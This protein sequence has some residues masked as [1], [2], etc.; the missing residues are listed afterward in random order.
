M[1]THY[2]HFKFTILLITM[3]LLLFMRV[4]TVGVAGSQWAIDAVAAVVVIAAVLAACTRKRTR[5]AAILFS[6]PPL[7]LTVFAQIDPPQ[8][9]PTTYVLLKATSATFL[10]FMTLTIVGELLH[11][12][13]I[14]R[15]SLAGAFCGYLLIGFSWSD[16]FCWIDLVSPG[17][18]SHA[19]PVQV[20]GTVESR[21]RLMHYFSFVTLT[22]IGYGDIVPVSPVA[23]TL[24]C[25]EAICGQF[26]LAILVAGLVSVRISQLSNAGKSAD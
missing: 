25:L 21:S 5:V 10:G 1:I 23:R 16:L 7:L 22:T 13:E 19:D 17:S 8:M 3:F 20:T 9:E 26:Y 14:T 6:I 15:D 4:C 18:F 12:R 2:V 11:Q 24:A